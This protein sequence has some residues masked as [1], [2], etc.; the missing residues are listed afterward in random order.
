MKVFYG[1]AIQGLSKME[2]RAEANGALIGE[3]KRLGF[4][5]VTE[6]TKGRTYEE[7]ME[8]LE[9]AIG[10]LPPKGIERKVFVR[11]K[12]VQAIEGDITAAVFE[13][14]VPSLGTGVEVAHAYLRPRMGL[15]KIPILLLYQKDYW[16]NELS[17]MIRGIS[18]GVIPNVKLAEYENLEDARKKLAGFLKGLGDG[19]PERSNSQHST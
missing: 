5:V 8:H 1:A 10:P 19:D 17:T 4:E 16:P 15:K 11:G 13:V 14:S 9:K 12:M 18:N 2:Q 7:R 6:H 3:I